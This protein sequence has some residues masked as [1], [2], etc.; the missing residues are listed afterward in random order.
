[1]KKSYACVVV[2]A[3]LVMGA[4]S[5]YLV[6]NASISNR[7]IP[8]RNELLADHEPFQ[9]A[10]CDDQHVQ[11][12]R[13]DWPPRSPT[14]NKRVRN[15]PFLNG[16]IFVSTEQRDQAEEM[17][18]RIELKRENS[19][20]GRERWNDQL[21]FPEF[22]WMSRVRVW[23]DD[24]QWLWP[25]LPFLLRAH[26]VERQQRYGG[27]DPGSG[28][29]NDFAAVVV[30]AASMPS[31]P[32]L[33]TA[34]WFAPPV[35]PV[36]KHTVIHSAVSDDLHAVIDSRDEQQGSFGVWLIYADFIGYRPPVS[37]PEE[38][39]FDGGILAYFSIDWEWAKGKIEIVNVVNETP[40]SAT[41]VNWGEWFGANRAR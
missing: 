33:I 37:W 5:L 12:F 16:T 30:R 18:L 9:F 7:Q 4:A 41:G 38:P 10:N 36:D 8:S 14:N 35:G 11:G 1:M 28:I 31:E 26:G 24:E 3:L 29:D 17:N 15:A 34:E 13:V 25:N 20:T 6:S 2:T 27:V 19:A 39:G 40:P 22:D 23:D 21:A 32:A